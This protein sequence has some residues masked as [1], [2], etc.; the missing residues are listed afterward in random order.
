MNSI[1]AARRMALVSAQQCWPDGTVLTRADVIVNG[2]SLAR[3]GRREATPSVR[4]GL[5]GA[6]PGPAGQRRELFS[7][8]LL[9]R[10]TAVFEPCR[11]GR[12]EVW[13]DADLGRCRA[14]LAAARLVGRRARTRRRSVRLLS[15]AS[16]LNGGPVLLPAD[17]AVGDLL[18]IPCRGA[19]SR[20]QV[21]LRF[22][23]AA[24]EDG[25]E[26]PPAPACRR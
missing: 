21:R 7:T 20:A 4:I 23:G 9:T 10:V 25:G 17:I 11:H 6:G 2:S 13:V 5:A 24:R 26:L 19:V 16:D 18:A 14:V 8:V 12:S 3:A 15:E 1:L 22:P